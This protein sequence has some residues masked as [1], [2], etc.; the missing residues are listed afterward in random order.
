MAELYGRR[1][2]AVLAADTYMQRRIYR[3]AKLDSHFHQL[4]YA[5]LI[6]LGK[7]IVLEDLGVIVSV[8][9]LSCIVTGETKGHL[10]QVVCTEA[11]EVS[12]FCYIVSCKSCS[13][14]LNHCTYFIIKLYV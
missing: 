11:E 9:E 13:R 8:Q 6:Q 5:G 4:A 10:S 14:D 12:F 2:S 3:L 7:R 1:I